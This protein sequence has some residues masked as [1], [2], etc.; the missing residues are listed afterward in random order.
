MNF[1]K[2]NSVIT[3]VLFASSLIGGWFFALPTMQTLGILQDNLVI[4]ETDLFALQS[5]DEAVSRTMNFYQALSEDDVELVYLALP[6][7]SQ[8]H[9]LAVL[10][11]KLA[12]GSGLVLSEIKIRE[13]KTRSN[14]SDAVLSLVTQM[15]LQGTYEEL[16]KFIETTGDLLRIFDFDTMTIA[17]R[18]V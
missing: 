8:K 3:I 9:E 5:A 10:L 4:Q 17:R 2:P 13:S 12:Q 6:E 7:S 16:K 1:L 15:E 11:N 18:S 14:E